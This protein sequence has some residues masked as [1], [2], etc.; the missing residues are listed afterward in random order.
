MRFGGEGLGRTMY[1]A[2][3]TVLTRQGYRTAHAGIALPNPASVA[4]HGSM[5]FSPV[6]V[7]REVG[8]K[9][10]AWHDVGWW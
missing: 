1:A 8:W 5:G 4:L 2:L 7:F 10:G 9:L 6:G 3:F